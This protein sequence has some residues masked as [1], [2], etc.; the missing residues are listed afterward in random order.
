MRDEDEFLRVKGITG[1]AEVFGTV[2]PVVNE[3][4]DMIDFGLVENEKAVQHIDH[5]IEEIVDASVALESYGRVLRA[6]KWD[7]ISKQ[8]A[9]AM[10]IGLSRIDRLTGDRSDLVVALEDETSGDMKRIGNAPA[11]TGISAVVNRAKELLQK[12]IEKIVEKFTQLKATAQAKWQQFKE[13]SDAKMEKLRAGMDDYSPN[14]STGGL[15]I[16]VPA[17]IAAMAYPGGKYEDFSKFPATHQWIAN[18]GVPWIRKTISDLAKMD[19]TE[20]ADKIGADVEAPFT[21]DLPASIEWSLT[22]PKFKGGEGESTEIPVRDWQAMGRSLDA[23]KKAQE[24]AQST[25]DSLSAVSEAMIGL[26][27][28][29]QSINTP[30]E[31]K[32][33][34]LQG[35]IFQVSTFASHLFRLRVMLN[36]VIGA[37]LD[38]IGAEQDASTQSSN[39][40]FHYGLEDDGEEPAAEPGKLKALAQKLMQW[41]NEMWGKL[42]AQWEK[43]SQS[44]AIVEQKAT[45]AKEDIKA[46]ESEGSADDDAS[47]PRTIQVNP[48]MA[49]RI[50]KG[51]ELIRPKEFE[52]V[53]KYAFQ[54]LGAYYMPIVSA[55]RKAYREENVDELERLAEAGIKPPVFAGELP[56]GGKIILANGELKVEQ[57]E[58]Q[59]FE[60]TVPNDV[61][62]TLSL[63]EEAEELSKK[64]EGTSG[65][66]LKALSSIMNRFRSELTSALTKPTTNPDLVKLTQSIC[67]PLTQSLISAAE[68]HTKLSRV[69]LDYM[70][71]GIM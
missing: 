14:G 71:L 65:H 23:I 68:L 33:A 57:E 30:D 22:G 4:E 40:E 21:H 48:D 43:I 37:M 45:A 1:E 59:G 54:D 58:A 34:L 31:A 64:Q 36:D 32:A 63:I 24:A 20:A 38:V 16:T 2:E 50:F 3:K 55:V 28:L 27:A 52:P 15:K 12:L 26:S 60:F 47:G 11:A 46:R 61:K 19:G 6:S 5:E 49:S 51:Q 42:V 69:P 56:T 62:A 10:A 41:I 17:G 8:T 18:T 35:I 25:S 44:H 13:A 7:G 70:A 9:K 67:R 39:E 66:D 29:K 53:F